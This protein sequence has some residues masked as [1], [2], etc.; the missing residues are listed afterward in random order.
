MTA[1]DPRKP[2]AP[3]TTPIPAPNGPNLDMAPM[4]ESTN[5][6]PVRAAPAKSLPKPFTAVP[7]LPLLVVAFSIPLSS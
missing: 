2:I 4:T 1:L 7:N 3:A 5:I 6:L